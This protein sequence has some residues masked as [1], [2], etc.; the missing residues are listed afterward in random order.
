MVE[1]MATAPVGFN[2]HF[3]LVRWVH[4]E[5]SPF[6]A[7]GTDAHAWATKQVNHHRLF[8]DDHVIIIVVV[9]VV[10][11]VVLLLLLLLA[12][13]LVLNNVATK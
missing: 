12:F 4:P 7:N 6:E 1:D 3:T 9:V 5:P 2:Y 13:M 11:V 8:E 10:V